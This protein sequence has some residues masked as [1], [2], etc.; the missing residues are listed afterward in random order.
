LTILKIPGARPDLFTLVHI[1]QPITREGRL[2][3]FLAG[4]D[5]KLVDGRARAQ[6]KTASV[7]PPPLTR[8]E[9]EI[10][11]HL[12]AGLQNKEV[13]QALELSVA[14]VRNHVHNILEKLGVHSKLEAVSL[15]FR[16]GWVLP[17]DAAIRPSRRITPRRCQV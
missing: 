7:P 3:E 16:N 8:R 12:A 13:A 1:V 6:A 17:D 15:A 5:G 9:G 4:V 14:T 2:A 10:L 11:G